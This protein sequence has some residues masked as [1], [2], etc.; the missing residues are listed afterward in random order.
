MQ[1]EGMGRTILAR[2]Y[3]TNHPRYTAVRRRRRPRRAHDW[4]AFD[5]KREV[6]V[7]EQGAPTR[8]L[9]GGRGNARASSHGHAQGNSAWAVLAAQRQ[10]RGVRSDRRKATPWVG[11]SASTALT[12]SL[13]AGAEWAA[14]YTSAGPCTPRVWR[15]RRNSKSRQPHQATP[16]NRAS[17]GL[18]P[19]QHPAG[20][21]GASA[22]RPSL[23]A[24][25]GPARRRRSLE[26]VVRD[27]GQDGK[28]RA[29]HR[30]LQTAD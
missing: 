23:G 17:L 22:R 8:G 15:A 9:D 16:V 13:R 1:A 2:P 24:L 19:G 10:R 7:R 18:I 12:Q 3:S 14:H 11:P 29:S 30:L 4:P 25:L 26:S 20:T 6:S 28:G 5:Q 21:R 27:L